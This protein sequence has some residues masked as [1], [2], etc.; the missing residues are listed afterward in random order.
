[1]ASQ[2]VGR[3]VCRSYLACQVPWL[4]S[5]PTAGQKLGGPGHDHSPSCALDFLGAKAQPLL[6]RRVDGQYPPWR[7]VMAIRSLVCEN[8][9]A[10]KR[11]S[12]RWRS[13][14][15]RVRCTRQVRAPVTSSSAA[16][17]R[18]QSVPGCVFAAPGAQRLWRG[19][20]QHDQGWLREVRKA[21][22]SAPGYRPGPLRCRSGAPDVF[23]PALGPAVPGCSSSAQENS[24]VPSSA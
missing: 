20:R 15:V 21:A 19:L 12:S 6:K 16:G 24:S 7:S 17:S 1:M 4:P 18:P 11:L 2:P 22:S 5:Q 23:Q 3:A 14:R 10:A 9:L 13:S 8:A